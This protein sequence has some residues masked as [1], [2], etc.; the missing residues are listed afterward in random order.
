[1]AYVSIIITYVQLKFIMAS[2][3]TKKT[4]IQN[5]HIS[6]TSTKSTTDSL[7]TKIDCRNSNNTT[8]KKKCGKGYGDSFSNSNN[9]GEGNKN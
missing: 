3:E 2:L 6:I 7:E 4:N 1:M 5:K 8:T 9:S